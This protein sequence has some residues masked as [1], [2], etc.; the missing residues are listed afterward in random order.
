MS[1]SPKRIAPAAALQALGNK[2]FPLCGSGARDRRSL[3]RR[4]ACCQSAVAP[5]PSDADGFYTS[6]GAV[7][8]EVGNGFS[9]RATIAST[10]ER[11]VSGVPVITALGPVIGGTLISETNR[12]DALDVFDAV[13]NGNRQPQRSAVPRR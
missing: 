10:A 2:A 6:D 1:R 4:T 9:S 12:S 5:S 7:P 3:R 8:G 13:L 11:S